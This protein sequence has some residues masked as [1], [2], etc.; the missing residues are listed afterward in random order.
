MDDLSL[1]ILDVV[2][3]SIDAG[4]KNI[5]IKVDEDMEKDILSI[6]I[7]DDGKGMDKET[8]ENVLD[9]FYTTR[10]TRRVGLGIPLFAEAA[11][12]SGG[13]IKIKSI[14]GT[15][16]EIN[17]TFGYSNIDRQPL[18]DLGETLKVLIFSHPEINFKFEHKKGNDKYCLDTGKQPGERR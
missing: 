13:D 14:P 5:G 8:Q 15:K 3:N 18:G 2:E 11:R 1:H 12:A 17:A 16:T 4:A 9:P 6:D 7:I 10:T